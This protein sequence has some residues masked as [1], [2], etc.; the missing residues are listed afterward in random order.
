[1]S[2]A[3]VGLAG[4]GKSNLLGF[5]CGRPEVVRSYLAPPAS[6][7]L[8]P[9]DLNNLPDGAAGPKAAI[10]FSPKAGPTS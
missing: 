2:G 5:L 6:V 9:A 3:V 7:V 4:A 8:V 10:A 1:V